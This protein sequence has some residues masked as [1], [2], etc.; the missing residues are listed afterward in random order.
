[1]AVVLEEESAGCLTPNACSANFTIVIHPA[2]GSER[3]PGAPAR[4]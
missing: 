3:R 4:T 1:V 2:P